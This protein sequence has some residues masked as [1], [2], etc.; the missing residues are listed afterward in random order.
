LSNPDSFNANPDAGFEINID[1]KLMP[2]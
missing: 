2:M 1:R